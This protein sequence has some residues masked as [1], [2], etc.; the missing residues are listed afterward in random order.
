MYTCTPTEAEALDHAQVVMHMG[1]RGL[2]EAVRQSERKAG[3]MTPDQLDLIGDVMKW[4]RELED[5]RR[6]SQTEHTPDDAGRGQRQDEAG[7]P[8]G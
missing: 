6:E 1:M 5:E 2:A 3:D 8:A 4:A 7:V